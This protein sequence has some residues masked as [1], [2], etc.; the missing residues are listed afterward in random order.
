M[1]KVDVEPDNEIEDQNDDD[2]NVTEN[3][4]LDPRAGKVHV[5]LPQLKFDATKFVEMFEELKLDPKTNT[6]TRKQLNN[7]AQQYVFFKY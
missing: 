5:D 4:P 7:L 1:D 3:N 2:L 6:K